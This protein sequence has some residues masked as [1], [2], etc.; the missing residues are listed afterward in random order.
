MI[1]QENIKF[2]DNVEA[3]Q[4]EGNY[5]KRY[6]TFR[7]NKGEPLLIF[8]QNQAAIMR[9]SRVQDDK[10]QLLMRIHGVF[11]ILTFSDGAY[12]KIFSASLLQ[13]VNL[14]KIWRVDANVRARFETNRITMDPKDVL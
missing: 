10:H 4:E 1:A 14:L 5:G 11:Y 7:N 12:A 13:Y 3:L 8:G 6:I 2:G 9:I